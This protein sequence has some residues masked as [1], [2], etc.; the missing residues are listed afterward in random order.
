MRCLDESNE[1]RRRALV[2]LSQCLDGSARGLCQQQL[3]RTLVS[4]LFIWHIRT[5]TWGGGKKRRERERQKN[6]LL[7]VCVCVCVCMFPCIFFFVM[8][9]DKDERERLTWERMSEESTF[10]NT[11]TFLKWEAIICV[12]R[13]KG[14]RF[15]VF[16]AWRAE[17]IEDD[18]KLLLFQGKHIKIKVTS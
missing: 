4:H 18:W 13:V 17:H 7:Y 8:C 16:R 10:F 15:D 5:R 1:L 14:Y 2:A 6:I 11:H 12:I 9:C 3:A